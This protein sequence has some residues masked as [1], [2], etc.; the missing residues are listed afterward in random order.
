MS[1]GLRLLPRRSSR[2][3]FV[4]RFSDPFQQPQDHRGQRPAALVD[5]VR[6]ERDRVE[7]MKEE[8]EAGEEPA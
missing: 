5:E 1:G 7:A 4:Q 6:A 3:L 8:L 2:S